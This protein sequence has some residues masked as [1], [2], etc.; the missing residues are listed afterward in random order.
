MGEKPVWCEE[1]AYDDFGGLRMPDAY[2]ESQTIKFGMRD[3][4]HARA[5]LAALAP[6]LVRVLLDVEWP[7]SCNWAADC[8]YSYC[9]SCDRDNEQGHGKSCPLD[10]ALTLAGLPTKESRDA[11]RELIQKGTKA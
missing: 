4:D 2:A 9:P 6:A 8:P 7:Y 3:E 10:A 1:W 11:A 5:S